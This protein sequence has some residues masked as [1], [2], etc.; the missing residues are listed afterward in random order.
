MFPVINTSEVLPFLRPERVQY[1]ILEV[2]PDLQ[3]YQQQT[4][5]QKVP[6]LAHR[7]QWLTEL[8]SDFCGII[9]AN[10]VLDALPVE[11]F[12]QQA[13]RLQQRFV[14]C[15]DDGNF[16]YLDAPIE[17]PRLAAV[18]AEHEFAEGYIGE[19]NLAIQPLIADLAN[20]L[21]QGAILFIDYGCGRA[22]LYDPA[23]NAGSLRC[24]S[25]QRVHADPFWYPGLQDIT[26]HVDFTQVAE[27]AVE[28][29]LSILG[30]AN[31]ASFLVNNG[32]MNHIDPTADA[33]QRFNWQQQLKQLLLPSEMG[34]IFKVI[35]LGKGLDESLPAL[36]AQSLLVYL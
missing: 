17:T 11:Q 36:S 26:A 15:T 23:R 13:G 32:I 28:Q 20:C 9:L 12:I 5:T 34:E 22:E 10:E 16:A 18:L 35:A 1:L 4:L 6:H 21:S 7:V 27:A 2:S 8:P 19:V 33:R 24:F 3:Q 14:T 31:Q 25:R 30:Y 29:G